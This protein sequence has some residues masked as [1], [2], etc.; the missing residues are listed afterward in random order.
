MRRLPAALLP[1]QLGALALRAEA[2]TTT[3]PDSAFAAYMSSQGFTNWTVV[4]ASPGNHGPAYP[5]AMRQAGTAGVVLTQIIVDTLGHADLRALRIRVA[6][7]SAFVAAVRSG[8][9]TMQF[10]PAEVNGRK[11]K[12]LVQLPFAFAIA[13]GAPEP[14]AAL[15]AVPRTVTCQ[16]AG[17]CPVHRMGTVVVTA[18]R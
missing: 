14:L 12:Q 8:L 6:T 4:Q 1:L 2:Q 11:V 15:E 3:A 13:G 9:E 17:V 7:D 10:V 5:A 16:P 18:A